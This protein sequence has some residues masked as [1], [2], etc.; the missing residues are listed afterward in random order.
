MKKMGVIPNHPNNAS[1]LLLVG[2]MGY[3]F[4]QK[5]VYYTADVDFYGFDI[6]VGIM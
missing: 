2:D 6:E 4:I 1:L 3:Q 5:G